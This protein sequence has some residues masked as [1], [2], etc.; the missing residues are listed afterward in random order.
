LAV[1]VV[2]NTIKL[3]SLILTL[4]VFR[5]YLRITKILLFSLNVYK[6]IEVIRKVIYKIK[7]IHT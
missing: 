6:R 2:N 4:L 7:K 5:A 1:K 3:N